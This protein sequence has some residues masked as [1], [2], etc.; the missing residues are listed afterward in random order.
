MGLTG[1]AKPSIPMTP[2]NAQSS[3]GGDRNVLRVLVEDDGLRKWSYGM[4]DCFADRRTC[5]CGLWSTIYRFLW[6]P[7]SLAN[8]GCL[9]FCCCCYVYSR[10][11]RRFDHLET[12]G[13]PLREPVERY[14]RDCK[15]YCLLGP[16]AVALQ[17][18]LSPPSP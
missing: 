6:Y 11:K 1:T 4:R 10:N 9:S 16:A 5:M 17:V 14:N 15:W 18:R 3:G 8:L 2:L 12:H 13:T 7:N